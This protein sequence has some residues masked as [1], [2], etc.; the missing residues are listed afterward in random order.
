[1]ERFAPYAY[2]ALVL[3]LSRRISSPLVWRVAAVAVAVVTVVGAFE[4]T[5]L[6]RVFDA[7]IAEYETAAGWIPAGATV[8]ALHFDDFHAWPGVFGATWRRADPFL[9]A[10]ANV[11]RERGAVNLRS[12]Q[13][14]KGYFPLAFRRERNPIARMS[15]QRGRPAGILQHPMSAS[16]A[17]YERTAGVPVDVVLLWGPPGRPPAHEAG[18]ATVAELAEHYRPEF[19]SPGRGFMRVLRREERD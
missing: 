12:Y 15:R 8:L 18:R 6:F 3:W 17:R 16:P 11:A 5:R 9:H 10:V 2:F 7:E 14:I 1:V 4:R 19:S 13:A